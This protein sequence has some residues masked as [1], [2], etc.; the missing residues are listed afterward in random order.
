[1]CMS[2]KSACTSR[3]NTRPQISMRSS[4][5]L[6]A[7]L[8]TGCCHK[9]TVAI[10][11]RKQRS[12]IRGRAEATG[13]FV[14]VKEIRLPTQRAAG[15]PYLDGFG[16]SLLAAALLS[17][18]QNGSDFPHQ[19]QLHGAPESRQL[20]LAQHRGGLG[21][22]HAGSERAAGRVIQEDGGQGSAAGSQGLTCVARERE[23]LVSTDRLSPD[24]SV[25][26]S[27]RDP[28]PPFLLPRAGKTV[29]MESFLLTQTTWALLVNMWEYV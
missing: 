15:R 17:A 14:S 4:S 25:R 19:Q 21:G 8:C 11:Q 23:A 5:G 28:F 22:G 10:I 20:A 24:G 7:L 2:L 1:M 12:E 27:R 6:L 3:S 13:D 26:L 16:S 9:P 29:H 18:I